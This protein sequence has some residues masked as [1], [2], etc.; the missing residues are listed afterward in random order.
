MISH[1]TIT[2]GEVTK[3]YPIDSLTV[4]G[5]TTNDFDG[6][7]SSVDY[8]LMLLPAY[9]EA[10][11]SDFC[12]HYDYAWTKEGIQETFIVYGALVKGENPF[13]SFWYPTNHTYD[14]FE[15]ISPD[16]VILHNQQES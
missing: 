8:Q 2:F 13:F 7:H 5:E 9:A 6:F 11:L 14:L 15:W 10:F 12:D 4:N 3:I 1:V 16:D